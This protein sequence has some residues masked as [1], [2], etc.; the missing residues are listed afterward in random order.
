MF[1]RDDMTETRLES[2][3]ITQTWKDP[4]PIGEHSTRGPIG[5]GQPNAFPGPDH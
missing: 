1:T 4:V 5:D 2:Q 3:A